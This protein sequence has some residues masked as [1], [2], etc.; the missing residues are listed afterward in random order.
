MRA[1][2]F[3]TEEEQEIWQNMPTPTMQRQFDQ[4]DQQK[5]GRN[6][7]T[8]MPVPRTTTS[9]GYRFGPDSPVLPPQD[10]SDWIRN[11]E[12]AKELGFPKG[13]TENEPK[14]MTRRMIDPRTNNIRVGPDITVQPGTEQYAE[15]RMRTDPTTGE[16]TPP[17]AGQLP[18]AGQEPPSREHEKRSRR[19]VPDRTKDTGHRWYQYHNH[20]KDQKY[21]MIDPRRAKYRT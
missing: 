8:T 21:K 15:L 7:L 4:W 13:W 1:Q 12:V 16:I 6:A 18:K 9:P 3:I 14:R 11:P 2:E 10:P 20:P 17:G 19:E 5:R